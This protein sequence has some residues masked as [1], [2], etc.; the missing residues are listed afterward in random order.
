VKLAEPNPQISCSAILL[1]L[2]VVVPLA[3][4]QT[5]AAPAIARPASAPAK[6]LAFDVVSV[7]PNKTEQSH[8]GSRY[9]PDGFD[10]ENDTLLGFI[11]YA[12]GFSSANDYN[13]DHLSGLP[14]WAKS[15]RFDIVAK[16]AAPDVA[17]WTDLSEADRE[18]MIR[19]VLA[20]RFKLQTHT[21]PRQRPIFALILS[22]GG[23]K[24]K[25]VEPPAKGRG[26]MEGHAPGWEIGHHVTMKQLT[27][28]LSSLGLGRQVQDRTHLTGN[29]DFSLTYAPIQP[30]AT[31]SQE[32]V[33]SEPFGPDIFTG[34]QVQLG[35][36]LE[37]ATGPIETLVVN[38]VERPSEN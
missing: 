19:E 17:A 1:A 9:R 3:L 20:D 5:A 18:K 10:S 30:S 2:F 12:Y 8:P 7:K 11:F 24:M 32:G 13:E 23:S 33:A 4:A 31:P 38:H 36:K 28:W 16:V 34:I 26:F 14:D 35:L 15:E 6:P 29:Y 21:E 22:K 27:T 37:P 25:Q